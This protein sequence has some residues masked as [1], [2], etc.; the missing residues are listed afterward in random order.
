MPSV[1]DVIKKQKEKYNT[2]NNTFN[3]FPIGTKVQVITLG[4]DH[5]FFD[6]TETGIV[7]KNSGR[8]L[9]IMIKFD[10]PRHFSDK[11]IQK[12]FNFEPNDLIVLEKNKYE[13]RICAI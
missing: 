1:A 2:I 9:G 12:E 5:N 6:G 7:I 4:Q 10:N 8:Y 11:Y 3:M 13:T